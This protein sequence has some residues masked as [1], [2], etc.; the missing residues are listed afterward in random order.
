MVWVSRGPTNIGGCAFDLAVDPSAPNALFAAAAGG[1]TWRLRFDL[2]EIPGISIGGGL[3]SF[4]TE[5][6][7]FAV[8]HWTPT[9]DSALPFLY[10]TALAVC[11][12]RPDVVYAATGH[13]NGGWP[14]QVWRSDNRG[15]SWTLPSTQDFGRVFRIAVD[16]DDSSR[17]FV[18]GT[19]GLWRSTDSG[20]SWDQLRTQQAFDVAID[21]D[22]PDIVFA[23]IDGVGVIRSSGAR[24][25]TKVGG[26]GG[27]ALWIPLWST[28]LPWSRADS[29]SGPTIRIGLGGG[30]APESRTVAVKFAEEIFINRRGGS[31]GA[32]AWQSKGKQGGSGYSW[33][34]HV[35]AVD[36]FNSNVI[37]A[38]AEN[39]FR[40]TNGGTGWTQV[41]GYGSAAHADQQQV[42]FD[43]RRPGVV[44]LANDGGIW[45]S[46]DSGATWPLDLNGGF[47]TAEMFHVGISGRNAMSDMYHQGLVGTTNVAA[48]SWRGYEG[49]AWEFA[50]VYGDPKR[51]GRFYVFSSK[52]GLRRLFT[53]PDGTEFGDFTEVGDFQPSSIDFDLRT[54]SNTIVVG[55]ADGRIMRARNGDSTTPTWVAMN[56]VSVGGQ[57]IVGLAFAPSDPGLCWA[58]SADGK[59][60]RKI[61]VNTGGGWSLRGS[62]SGG[63]I[64]LAVNSCHTDHIYIL[65]DNGLELSTDGGGSFALIN[66]TGTS[67]LP[68]R[69]LK[70]VFAHPDDPGI[71]IVGAVG[72]VYLSTDEGATWGRYDW[73][74]PNAEIK[75]VF[76]VGDVLYAGTVGRGLWRRRPTPII[77]PISEFAGVA[78][79]SK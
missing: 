5:S 16:P 45:G 79:L 8:P 52:L 64:G 29:P 63:V 33:W 61:D 38:G 48:T 60:L 58:I 35:I 21:P 62:T 7:Y 75:Q 39:L 20:G 22:D 17:L 72:G 3:F 19:G 55:T 26:L 57:A 56:G 40:T 47:V 36:P 69:A 24:V 9:T 31:G 37:L 13:P 65:R 44:Y 71:L 50:D 76:M 1:G 11:E 51:P 25:G 78:H 77:G 4:E 54:G 34:C 73:N 15:A 70:S 10:Q 49:G 59:V 66:G 14:G 30:G 28:I 68:S 27:L 12:N 74:L 2:Y 42:A 53:Q 46:R 23:G 43:R 32:S 41:A 18:A 6:Q 67:S